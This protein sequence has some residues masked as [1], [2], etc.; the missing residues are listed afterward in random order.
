MHTSQSVRCG[1]SRPRS[2]INDCRKTTVHKRLVWSQ[3][4]RLGRHSAHDFPPTMLKISLHVRLRQ[5]KASGSNQDVIS[6]K[7]SLGRFK[8]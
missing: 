6:L 4:C 1:A 2:G 8:S 5:V 7:M 3:Y